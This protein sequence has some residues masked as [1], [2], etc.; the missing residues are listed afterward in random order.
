M[1][2]VTAVGAPG[3]NGGGG[4]GNCGVMFIGLEP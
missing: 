2:V 3:E 1:V 4:G